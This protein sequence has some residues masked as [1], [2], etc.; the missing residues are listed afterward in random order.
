MR[1][2]MVGTGLTWEEMVKR[3]EMVRKLTIH[4]FARLEMLNYR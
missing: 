1:Y 3:F 4:K 2:P